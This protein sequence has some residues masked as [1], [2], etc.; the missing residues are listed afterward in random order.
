MAISIFLIPFIA[1]LDFN[2]DYPN[3]AI[4]DEE[5]SVNL[6]L[7]TND[8]YDV[9]I[10][11]YKDSKEYS[12]ILSGEE[13]KS[14]KY[15][16]ISAYPKN[17]EFKLISH[18]IG[19]TEICVR[20]R[21]TGKS[22]FSEECKPILIKE[23]EDTINNETKK[24]EK[25]TQENFSSK[26][27]ADDPIILNSPISPKKNSVLITRTEKIRN[28]ILYSFLFLAVIIIILLALRKL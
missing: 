20:L 16:L 6:D 22:S 19:D 26:S 14:P 2:F 9:K 7:S 17:K 13:W 1:S 4:Q 15:Y 10:F 25:E 28:Y 21:E 12:E 5:F 8:D 18:Y 24:L 3:S 11:I 23:K 27:V